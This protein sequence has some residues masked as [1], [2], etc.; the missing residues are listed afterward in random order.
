MNFD[1]LKNSSFEEG[2]NTQ[3]ISEQDKKFLYRRVIEDLN[4]FIL[5]DSRLGKYRHSELNTV[6]VI[7]LLQELGLLEMAREFRK[8]IQS[9]LPNRD[10]REEAIE[11]ERL[12]RILLKNFE[13]IKNQKTQV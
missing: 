3:E 2:A 11:F 8:K 7:K 4:D 5:D 9:F 10:T 13:D 6:G 12:A 1:G